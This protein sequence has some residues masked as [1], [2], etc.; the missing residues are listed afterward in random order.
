MSQKQI[1]AFQQ[2][3]WQYYDQHGRRELLW[4]L[5]EPNGDFSPY[6]IL[7]SE[8]MLQQTQ[9]SRVLIKY[10]QFLELFPAVTDLAQASLG[11]ALTAWQ[12]LGYNRRAKFLWQ[13]AQMVVNEYGG[14][15]PQDQHELTKLPGVG[16]NTAGAVVAY[17]YNQPAA[18]IETNIRTVFIHHFF[19]DREEVHDKEIAELVEKTLP[20]GKNA[21]VRSWYW[22]LM[23]YG[24]HLKQTV[25]N[26]SRLSK[27]YAKQSP[28]HGSR[29]AVRGAVIRALSQLNQESNQKG[30]GLLQE[31][32]ANI[33]TDPR[34]ADVLQDLKAE[35]M[36]QEQAGYYRFL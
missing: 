14:E 17:A 32:L 3:V 16:V 24:S 27:S 23:D 21:D 8:V 9:V 7:V 18:F 22:A 12:G 5:P 1:A 28:F 13:A 30:Q 26:K 36:V 33:I 31:E 35:G 2:T 6:K 4:R 10:V 25:G 11:E 34:L 19:G 20:H 29:R 15:F